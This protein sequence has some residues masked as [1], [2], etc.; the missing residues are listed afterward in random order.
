[1]NTKPVSGTLVFCK[2]MMQL[3]TQENYNAKKNHAHI[4]TPH[5]LAYAFY[6]VLP[7]S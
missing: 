3:I 1:M 5:F 4:N 7:V 6:F 2:R